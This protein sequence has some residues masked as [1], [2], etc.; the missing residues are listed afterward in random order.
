M[1]PPR[2]NR[3]TW[4]DHHMLLAL[5]TA[6]RS[7]DPNTQVGAIAVDNKNRII[8]TGYNGTARRIK[9]ELI[10]WSRTADDPYNT[11]YPFVAHAEENVVKNTP[12]HVDDL[13]DSTIFCTMYPCNECAKDLL[14]VG[15]RKVVYLTNPYEG[16]WSQRA[17]EKMFE[18]A[19]V[20][21]IQHKWDNPDVV[22]E[23]LL[24]LLKLVE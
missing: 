21:V 24:N 19:Q 15:V 14:Q 20:D 18:L 3:L 7:P 12:G 23:L 4:S 1:Q 17:A 13:N 16:T 10:D 22:K 6:Q 8:A 5:T 11:K 2:T 9:P